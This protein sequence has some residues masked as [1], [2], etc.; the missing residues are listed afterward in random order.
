LRPP[1]GAGMM[2]VEATHMQTKTADRWAQ[3][4]IQRLKDM[5]AYHRKG[6]SAVM[7]ISYSNDAYFLELETAKPV[8]RIKQ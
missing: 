3:Q 7:A 1:D 2:L 6:G 5:A 8:E 4:E